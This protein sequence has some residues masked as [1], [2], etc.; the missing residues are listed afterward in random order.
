MTANRLPVRRGLLRSPPTSCACEDCKRACETH[1][2]WPTPQ[3]AAQLIANGHAAELML[4]VWE[5][6]GEP[7]DWDYLSDAPIEILCPAS[8]GHGGGYVPRSS[9]M[10]RLFGTYER[11]SCV[12]L[13]KGRRC[14]LYNAPGRP[15][16][17]RVG[18]PHGSTASDPVA[19]NEHARIALDR[20]RAVAAA[21]DTA[22]GR[23]LVARWRQLVELTEPAPWA[24][25]DDEDGDPIDFAAVAEELD[26]ITG[27]R[28][29]LG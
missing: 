4:D 11:G 2:G 3:E 28:L 24:I 13:T 8:A 15:L 27:G 26:E 6:G 14:E 7:G 21:W 23:A 25:E 17:C 12:F 5:A 10:Q 19:R 18:N 20:H 16:E 29:D 1:P 9:F 22:A